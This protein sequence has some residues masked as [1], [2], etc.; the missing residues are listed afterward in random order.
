M[1]Q[2]SR[3]QI[4]R[5]GD[6]LRSA[7]DKSDLILLDVFRRSFGSAYETVVQNIRDA[8]EL[9]PSGRPA[10]STNSLIE[11]LKR[12]SI[13]LTQVQDI[14]GCRLVV[15]NV[16]EDRVVDSLV[17]VFSGARVTDRREKPSY[18]YRAVHVIVEV[19]GK[20]V[21]IQIRTTFQHIWG[22]ISEKYADLYGSEI[23]YGSG[24]QEIRRTLKRM[25]DSI[26]RYE[27]LERRL[28]RLRESDKVRE[29]REEMR[30]VRM[31]LADILDEEI[32]RM[33]NKKGEKP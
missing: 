25:S 11:K 7:F 17:N 32:S 9:E 20:P 10:K 16:P 19:L 24:F 33:E 31:N 8:L 30:R 23:K 22:E 27:G 12:E 4:D 3:T 1:A 18:G 2:A 13:R 14:A 26:A 6:R 21:E 15:P 28:A 5:L 29:I